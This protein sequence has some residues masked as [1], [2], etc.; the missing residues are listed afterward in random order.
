MRN[1]SKSVITLLY[2]NLKYF[3]LQIQQD[4]ATFLLPYF[5][6]KTTGLDIDQKLK[7]AKRIN[8]TCAAKDNFNSALTDS[9]E[10][11]V[12]ALYLCVI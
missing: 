8:F 6:I 5:Q 11:T 7:R 3:I 4:S 9:I 1:F 2:I 12:Y 10:R